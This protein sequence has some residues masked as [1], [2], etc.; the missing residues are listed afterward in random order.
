MGA[1]RGF[2]PTLLA[3]FPWAPASEMLSGGWWDEGK[4]LAGLLQA[5]G[6]G[7]SARG[8]LGCAQTC[9]CFI[10]CAMHLLHNSQPRNCSESATIN[11]T[12]NL[13][14]FG[15]VFMAQNMSKRKPWSSSGTRGQNLTI[16]NCISNQQEATALSLL[17][18]RKNQ[19]IFCAQKPGTNGEK[20]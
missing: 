4:L 16:P 9:Q 10:A 19:C 12:A 1:C 15:L 7:R 11:K 18:F 2:H 14:G 3:E 20:K 17:N 6:A 13:V 8:A 5:D